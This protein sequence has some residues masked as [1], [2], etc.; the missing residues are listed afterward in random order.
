M[1][2]VEQL[3]FT[4]FRQSYIESRVP[5]TQLVITNSSSS[6]D[7][8]ATILNK[9]SQSRKKNISSKWSYSQRNMFVCDDLH[10]SAEVPGS[11]G[12]QNPVLELLLS[13]VDH[14]TI[15]DIKRNYLH[16]VS[17]VQLLATCTVSGTR[18]LMPQLARHLRVVPFFPLSYENIHSILYWNSHNWLSH[19]PDDLGNV[20]AISHVS[21]L[22]NTLI[23]YVYHPK[24]CPL[25]IRLL[26]QPV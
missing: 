16:N 4:F 19:S 8:H 26:P 9:L 20:D 10:M 3:C 1:M 17:S 22:Y 25:F 23:R 6:S 13:L 15:P 7:I 2:K 12:A 11:S 21:Y 24:C 18:R 5:V 14:T